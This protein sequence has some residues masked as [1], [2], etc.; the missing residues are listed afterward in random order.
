MQC[1]WLSLPDIPTRGLASALANV[2]SARPE[3]RSHVIA[4]EMYIIMAEASLPQRRA[5][6]LAVDF[7]LVFNAQMAQRLLSRKSL[8]FKHLT[9]IERT[10]MITAAG[11]DDKADPASADGCGRPC[12]V[13]KILCT[14]WSGTVT[15]TLMVHV[16]ALIV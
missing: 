11:V 13:L 10:L 5:I 8:H 15:V 9:H 7:G 4:D 12:E 3:K 2:V 6:Q 14:E 1:L 16:F